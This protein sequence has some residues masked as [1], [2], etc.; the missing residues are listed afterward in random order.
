MSGEHIPVK[1]V[2]VT[3][4][5]EG[6]NDILAF[7][8]ALQQARPHLAT[9]DQPWAATLITAMAAAA[10]NIK[11]EDSHGTLLPLK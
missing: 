7:I 5:L 6:N 10:K 9:I 1:I 4:R 8:D 11:I 2:A 3:Y